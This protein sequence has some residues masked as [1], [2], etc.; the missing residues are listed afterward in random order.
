MWIT[1][2]KCLWWSSLLVLAYTYA[3]Y[4]LLLWFWSRVLVRP[5]LA[6]PE[7]GDTPFI[8]LII[9]AYNEQLHLAAKLANTMAL[10]YPPE[11][12]EVIVVSD[13]ST[14]GTDAIATAFAERADNRFPLRL[15][16]MSQREGKTMAQNA[17]VAIARGDILLF[18]D[19]TSV[20][21]SDVPRAILK[22]FVDARV[23]CVSGRLIYAD[24][25]KTNVGRGAQLYWGFETFLKQ[26]ESRCGSLIGVSGCLYAV[27]HDA[28]TPLHAEACSDFIIA[29]IMVE[30]GL[31][32]VYE[33]AAVCIE[34]TNRSAR[35]ELNMRVRIVAQ[36]LS[37]LW[38]HRAM[39][40]PL[41]SGFYAIQLFSH[42]LLRYC[43][44]LPLLAC[45]TA[46]LVLMRQSPFFAVAAALQSLLYTF[47]ALGWLADRYQKRQRLLSLPLYFV[48]TNIASAL[49]FCQFLRGRKYA[50]W[51]TN[52][53]FDATSKGGEIDV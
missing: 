22:G 19:A 26:C 4:P 17:A 25:G 16:R 7:P 38:R 8:S 46:S 49:G 50:H 5:R 41:R 20:Y 53:R 40:N 1:A 11:R 45:L 33:P 13:C 32:A 14:D 36:T 39:F 44:P 15:L 10:D 35:P 30:R 48:L 24:P 9:T 2:T 28:Y 3:G 43:T 23:G 42:K 31:R 29:T 34:E 37:D 21:Q 47:A 18:S 12:L 51:E 27:R 6:L 52:R